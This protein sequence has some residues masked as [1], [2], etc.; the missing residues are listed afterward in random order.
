MDW[1]KGYSLRKWYRELK[2]S[3]RREFKGISM[4]NGNF[5]TYLKYGHYFQYSKGVGFDQFDGY[6]YSS[7][8]TAS[9]YTMEHRLV[10]KDTFEKEGDEWGSFS[11]N[12]FNDKIIQLARTIDIYLKPEDID[13]KRD[14]TKEVDRYFHVSW[15][16]EIR[17]RESL[18]ISRGNVEFI[19]NNRWNCFIEEG[20]LHTK[21][22]GD[23]YRGLIITDKYHFILHFAHHPWW[24]IPIYL[25]S[26]AI[27][28]TQCNLLDLF[29]S[30]L[31][32]YIA[33]HLTPFDTVITGLTDK[34]DNIELNIDVKNLLPFK[35]Q[36]QYLKDRV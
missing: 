28:D 17:Q 29:Q 1:R 18:K 11:Q 26:I 7:K 32:D 21:S 4:L 10:V 36:Y 12:E 5:I 27:Y 14:I 19:F 25:R 31:D 13:I 3:T 16:D 20:G 22:K 33:S 35:D 30:K 23:D 6:S 9:I 15:K 8:G 2:V 24:F 34:Y